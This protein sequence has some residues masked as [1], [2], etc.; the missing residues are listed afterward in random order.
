MLDGEVRDRCA[1]DTGADGE[2]TRGSVAVNRNKVDQRCT[3]ARGRAGDG[4]RRW[5]TERAVRQRDGLCRAERVA[6]KVMLP[7]SLA[8]AARASRRLHAEPIL[9]DAGQLAATPVASS[10][11]VETMYPGIG[12][13]FAVI[14]SGAFMVTA[15]VA[16]VEPVMSLGTLPVQSTK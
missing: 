7:P 9:G 3:A 2:N 4:C 15:A 8:A 1:G 5:N 14:N 10:A 11:V 13:K 12:A 16:L 6:S